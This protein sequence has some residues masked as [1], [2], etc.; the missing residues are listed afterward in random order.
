M[1]D[2]QKKQDLCCEPTKLSEFSEIFKILY[3]FLNEYGEKKELHLDIRS[4]TSPQVDL[5]TIR[6]YCT[7]FNIPE[8]N[9][10]FY[11]RVM[12]EC[13]FRK[14]EKKLTTAHQFLTDVTPYQD[15]LANLVTHIITHNTKGNE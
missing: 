1:N 11:I 8:K 13:L 3:G 12:S 2:L 9:Q 6:G 14:I 10:S 4:F 7:H 5:G 15:S